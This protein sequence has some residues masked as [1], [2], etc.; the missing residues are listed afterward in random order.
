MIYLA[1]SLGLMSSLHCV[2]MCGPIALAL[3]VHQRS[4]L[5]KITGILL[6]NLGRT[7]TYTLLG[8]LLGFIGNALNLAG[9]QRGLSVGTGV[10]MLGA[11]AYS[12][13]WL[14]R[15]ATPPFLQKGVQ[16]VKKK[17]GNLLHNRSFSALFLLGTLNGLLPCGLVYMALISSVAAGNVGEGALFMALFGIG[18]VPAMSAAAFIKNLF[19]VPLRNRARRLMPAFVAAVAILLI[20]RGLEVKG[21]PLLGSETRDIPICHTAAE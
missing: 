8:F 17:L 21:W 7:F 13:H 14:D 3:P 12:S 19:S 5:G 4:P 6:Y 2:G 10:L 11:A 16:A 18:T 15:L 20:L 1:F 9:L